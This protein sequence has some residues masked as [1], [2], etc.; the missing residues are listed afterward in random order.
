MDSV[1]DVNSGG[2]V[3]FREAAHTIDIVPGETLLDCARRAAVPLASSCGGAGTCL[4]CMI[5]ITDGFAPE[6]SDADRRVFS[7][8][9]IATGWRRA[10]QVRLS[11]SCKVHVPARSATVGAVRIL[12]D[13]DLKVTPDPLVKSWR[14][15]VCMDRRG[16]GQGLDDVLFEAINSRVEGRCRTIDPMV[17]PSPCTVESPESHKLMA[18]VRHGE[19]INLTPAQ[20]PVLG[21]AVDLG[22]SSVGAF[23]VDMRRG[24]VIASEGCGNP[25]SLFGD[26]IVTRLNAAVGDD[27]T[28]TELQRQIIRSI[29]QLTRNLTVATDAA[30]SDVADIV[31][32]GNS[33]MQHFLLGLPIAG[34]ARAPFVSTMRRAV[35]MKARQLGFEAAPG[36]YVHVFPGIAGFIGGDHVA[37]L[38]AYET[39]RV[40]GVSLLLDIGTNTEISLIRDDQILAVSSPS[41]PALEGGEITWGMRAMPG[42]IESVAWT[43]GALVLHTIDNQS[44]EGLCGSGVIDLV[45]TLLEIGATNFRGRLQADHPR[46]REQDGMLEFVLVDESERDGP[47][48]TFR[49]DDMR[50]VQLAKAAIRAG[51]D[52]LLDAADIDASKLEQ[53]AIAGA[54]GAYI[55]IESA[56]AIGLLPDLSRERFEQIGDAAGLGARLATVSYPLRARASQLAR[57]VQ[58]VEMAGT[59]R[60]QRC[61]ARQI[62][63]TQRDKEQ[64]LGR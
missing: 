55:R 11:A 51:I 25:Q 13:G 52:T 57:R 58:N 27:D 6:P 8:K 38:L 28:A 62:N 43:D 59:P 35:D 5:R 63:F 19:L 48:I 34:L 36:A 22:T 12:E 47:A 23:L 18:V 2:R 3:F 37:A 33:A 4:T 54:F 49:Q 17:M 26:D 29:N 30:P 21:L 15:K 39:R 1:P 61:F 42:A 9:S 32:A 16:S 44:A 31:I 50:A 10:C 24:K 53:V 56:I 46:V 60:F 14:I 41:G 45:A 64:T 40:E 20:N 7:K